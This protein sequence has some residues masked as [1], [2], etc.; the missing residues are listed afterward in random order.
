MSECIKRL[1]RHDGAGLLEVAQNCV[2]FND[3]TWRELTAS[4][5]RA[6]NVLYLE[7]GK[8][9]RLRQEAP[10]GASACAA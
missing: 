5:T 7:H 4:D 1:A 2:I 3:G 9:M 8:P 10:E 6:D